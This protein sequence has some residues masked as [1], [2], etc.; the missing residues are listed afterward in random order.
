MKAIKDTRQRQRQRQRQRIPL[1]PGNRYVKRQYSSIDDSDKKYIP[2][3]IE[4]LIKNYKI[5][6]DDLFISVAW[7]FG[8]VC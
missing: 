8:I 6:K 1:Y 5:S 3:E 2:I 7:T 4:P